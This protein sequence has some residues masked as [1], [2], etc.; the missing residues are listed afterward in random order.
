MTQIKKRI[1]VV[2]DN[3]QDYLIFREVINQIRGFFTELEHAETLSDALVKLE[4]EEFDIVFLDLF[5]NDSFGKDTFSTVRTKT[6]APIVILSGLSDRKL[7]LEIVQEGAQDYLVKG[8]FDPMLLEKTIVYSI[9][10]RKYQVSMEASERR[11]RAIFESVGIAITEYDYT[12]LYH[13]I[14]QKKKA[15]AS[16]EKMI[17]ELDSEDVIELRSKMEVLNLNPE[18]LILHGCGSIEEFRQEYRNFYTKDCIVSFG[19]VLSAIWHEDEEMVAEVSFLDSNGDRM[20]TLKR[21]RFV[22]LNNG[23]YRLLVSTEDITQIK[24]DQ[25]KI[26]CQSVAMESISKAA[27]TLLQGGPISEL[28]QEAFSLVGDGLGADKLAAYLFSPSTD[29]DI[30]YQLVAYWDYE[31]RPYQGGG[32]GSTTALG[33]IDIIKEMTVSRPVEFFLNA[34]GP[35]VDAIMNLFRVEQALIAPIVVQ[36]KIMGMIVMAN[37]ERKEIDEHVNSGIM[38]VAG[39]IGSAIAANKANEELQEMNEQLE[40]RVDDRTKKMRQAMKELE[41]FSYSVSHDLRAPL[42]AISG[43]SGV[44]QE[45]YQE[46]LDEEGKRYLDVISEGAAEMSQLIDDLLDFSRIG[47]RKLSMLEVD[48]Q[49]LV[50]QIIEEQVAT[51][52]ERKIV[53]KCESLDPCVGDESM[54]RQVLYNFIRNAVK[55][56]AN[57]SESNIEISSKP[58]EGMIEYTIKDNG[59]GFDDT[60]A[61]KMFGVFQ[62]LHTNEEFE[63]T[64]VGLAI[65][66]RVI[67]RHGGTVHAQGEVDKGATFRFTLPQKGTEIDQ[68]EMEEMDLVSRL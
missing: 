1:L 46:K 26:F 5:L 4:N 67:H 8:E 64:G 37:D 31:N 29:F 9:E 30:H 58:L 60:Y 55:F 38:T 59:V 21:W 35:N 54:I 36:E 39:N 3:L 34:H 19:K 17:A 65:V 27:G 63:G 2:E 18:A 7:T 20:Y 11:Y 28:L 23:Y 40:L 22:G 68:L 15:G 50:Q 14:Q 42:R 33:V 52:G 53:F 32:A 51:A 12:N 57:E 56:T 43:F 44:L 66:Q 16:L 49:S 24:K 10:R 48:M 61:E 6:I 25:E 62:R 41:S 45:E 47:R 13:D